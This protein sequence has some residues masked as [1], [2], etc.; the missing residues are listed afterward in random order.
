MHVRHQKFLPVNYPGKEDYNTIPAAE[1]ERHRIL[2]LILSHLKSMDTS[3]HQVH[4]TSY[5][6]EPMQDGRTTCRTMCSKATRIAFSFFF[7]FSFFF[8]E[9]YEKSRITIFRWINK[10]IYSKSNFQEKIHF[11]S[12]AG[13]FLLDKKLRSL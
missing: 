2:K 11:F 8:F 13:N 6:F 9:C 7:S 4:Q 12:V 5:L 3:D 10:E 1:L